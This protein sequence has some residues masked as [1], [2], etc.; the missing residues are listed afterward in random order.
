MV[1]RRMT[2]N[3]E[4]LERVQE[5]EKQVRQDPRYRSIIEIPDDYPGL[6]EIHEITNKM[7][8]EDRPEQRID[9]V[10]ELLSSGYSYREIAKSLHVRESALRSFIKRNHLGN[11]NNIYDIYKGD[12]YVF[13]G[14]LVEIANHF[15]VKINTAR[16]Y[17]YNKANRQGNQLWGIKVG[18]RGLDE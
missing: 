17:V 18:R 1:V 16:F 5:L 4:L 2:I 12:R 3:R 14:T 8:K 11:L 13:T 6:K 10:K 7:N 9:S 15:E